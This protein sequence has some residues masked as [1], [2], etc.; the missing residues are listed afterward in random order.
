MDPSA[1]SRGELIA[2]YLNYEPNSLQNHHGDFISYL[3]AHSRNYNPFNLVFG[4]IHGLW[5]FSSESNDCEPLENGFHSISNGKIDHPWPKMS[6]GVD[7]L[8]TLI[9]NGSPNTHGPNVHSRDIDFDSLHQIMVDQTQASDDQLPNTGIEPEKE[10]MLSSIFIP[11]GQYGTRTTSML[12]YSRNQIQVRE[13]NYDSS[14]NTRSQQD[15]KL[16][17]T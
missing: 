3:R 12:L 5:V 4:N 6:L 1:I 16:K 7:R 2:R 9:S 13:I 8:T 11:G 15:F 10:R 14:S 17:T